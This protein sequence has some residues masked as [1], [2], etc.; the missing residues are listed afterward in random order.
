MFYGWYASMFLLHLILIW[1]FGRQKSYINFSNVF[2][3]PCPLVRLIW[4]ILL[5]IFIFSECLD[6]LKQ[7]GIGWRNIHTEYYRI[8]WPQ[9]KFWGV[10]SAL[11]GDND[12]VYAFFPLFFVKYSFLSN[13]RF[14]RLIFWVYDV[15]VCGFFTHT[16]HHILACIIV[17]VV[18]FR[19]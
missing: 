18:I 19:F 11:R 10:V 1:F 5:L 12:G 6:G 14:F 9:S 15:R 7:I 3:V 17:F 4:F 13:A 2:L 16:Q 8:N